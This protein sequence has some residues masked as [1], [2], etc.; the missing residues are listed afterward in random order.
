MNK[1]KWNTFLLCDFIMNP[2]VC[3][4][5]DCPPAK[6][7]KKNSSIS[8]TLYSALRLSTMFMSLKMTFY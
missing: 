6:K 2:L 8:E 4:P 5:N 1:K 7:K 3:Q